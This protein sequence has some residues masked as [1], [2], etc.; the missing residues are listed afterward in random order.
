VTLAD[1]SLL[2]PERTYSVAVSDFLVAGGDEYDMVKAAERHTDTFKQLRDVLAE[3][4]RKAGVIR[5]QSDGR[6]RDVSRAA[7]RFIAA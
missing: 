6:L 2:A 7:V 4:V 1:G 3:A 5:F